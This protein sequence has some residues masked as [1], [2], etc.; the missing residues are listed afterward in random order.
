MYMA[1]KHSHLTLIIISLIL[2]FVRVGMLSSG[3]PLNKFLKIYP[4]IN[5]TLLLISAITL[6][7]ILQQYPFVSPWLTLKLAFVVAYFVFV[8]KARY[9]EPFVACRR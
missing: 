1:F 6:S 8:F 5:D 3:K 7:V 9:H 2:L 4:H